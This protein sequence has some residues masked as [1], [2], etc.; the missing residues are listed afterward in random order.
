MKCQ[1]VVGVLIDYVIDFL[2]YPPLT[3]STILAATPQLVTV[4]ISATS[5]TWRTQRLLQV[6]SHEVFQY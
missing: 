1:V 3:L 4:G 2:G 5:S 6:L